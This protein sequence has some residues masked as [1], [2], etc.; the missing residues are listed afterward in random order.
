VT[1]KPHK[2]NGK[3]FWLQLFTTDKKIPPTSAECGLK[4]DEEY[5]YHSSELSYTKSGIIVRKALRDMEY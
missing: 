3:T 2:L 5:S 4:L 1:L